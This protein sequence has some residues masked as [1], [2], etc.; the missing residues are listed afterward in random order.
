MNVIHKDRA[1]PKKRSV[2]GRI[3]LAALVVAVVSL[4]Y[5]FWHSSNRK[6]I[7]KQ[8]EQTTASQAPINTFAQKPEGTVLKQLTGQQFF[9]LYDT[10]IYPNTSSISE[11]TPITGNLIADKRIRIVAEQRG[12]KLR[13]APVTDTF[14]EVQPGMKLQQRAAQPWFNLQAEAKKEGVSISLSAA[15]RSAEDQRSIFME[16]LHAA[17]VTPDVIAIGN[18]DTQVSN[19]L[20]MTA[21]PGYSRHHTGYTIDIACDDQPTTTF[22]YTSC[23]KWLSANNYEKVKKHG[24]IP[25]YPEGSGKQGP[26]PESWE[27]VWVGTQS[28][29]Q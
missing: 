8:Q 9:E 12:Y 2:T 20:R 3:L 11:E 10:F 5:W 19:L 23:F 13:S 18:Y 28:L 26:D 17:G 21:I 4:G 7:I 29:T 16:R 14:K 6:A 27:Y 24:W 15:F 22:D 1:E 25:S